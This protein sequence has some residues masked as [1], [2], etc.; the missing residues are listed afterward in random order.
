MPTATLP[1]LNSASTA[2]PL[3]LTW[4]ANPYLHLGPDRIYNPHTDRTL[5]ATEPGFNEL[6]TVFASGETLPGLEGAYLA[7]AEQGWLV[8]SRTDPDRAF[9]LKYVSLEAHTVC[10]QACYFCP[11][12]LAPR[13][14]YFMPMELYQRIVSEVAELRQPVE[15]LFMISY[16]EPT[17]DPRFLEQVQIIRAAGLPPA[18]LTNGTGLTPKRVDALVEMGGLRFLSINISTLDRDRY[19]QDRGHDHLQQVLRNLDYAKDRAVAQDMDIVVLGTGN[20]NHQED[21]RQIT[22]RFAGSRFNVKYFVVNDR[23]GYLQVGL[24]GR[25]RRGRLCGCNHMGSRPIQHLHITPKAE[26]IL[27]CQDYSETMVVGDLNRNSLREVLTG[28]DFARARR[29]VY[30]F[31]PV[32][33]NYICH[34]CEFA[35]KQAR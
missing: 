14:P 27:C 8:D 21:F 7:L 24:S 4:R 23:A 19:R 2:A 16:N 12:S 30:G 29:Q 10:N 18:T 26:C 1:V 3:A 28:D 31:E 25:E 34:N 22:A 17:A 13:E 11:V 9:Y 32:P 20:D 6:V 5:L 33:D 15:A 35:L